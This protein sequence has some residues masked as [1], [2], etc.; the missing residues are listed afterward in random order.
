M[1]DPSA[2]RAFYGVTV[3]TAFF[4]TPA[5]EAEMEEMEFADTAFVFTVNV[6]D[7]APAGMVRV[8]GT[9]ATAVLLLASF[10]TTPP[11]GAGPLKV[12]VP[13]EGFPPLTVVGLSASEASERV[14]VP[15]CTLYR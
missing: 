2:N 4:L 5:Y 14:A 13:C 10:T 6:A 11:A 3:N 1:K 8:R 12:T 15:V 7:L 9:C